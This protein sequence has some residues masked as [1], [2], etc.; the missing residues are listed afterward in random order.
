MLSNSQEALKT[1]AVMKYQLHKS[2]FGFEGSKCTEENIVSLVKEWAYEGTKL[3]PLQV[4]LFELPVLL[5]PENPK[6]DY[7]EY[8]SKWKILHRED[9][10][11]AKGAVDDQVVSKIAKKCKLFLHPD[12]WSQDLSDDQKLLLQAIWD[13]FQE[14]ALF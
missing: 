6:I 7:H 1:S 12:K 5:P 13:V 3:R 9:F 10:K 14:S 11:D 4:L 8:F 2:L